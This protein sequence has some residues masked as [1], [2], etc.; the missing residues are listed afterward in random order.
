[1]ECGDLSPLFGEGFSLH[2]LGVSPKWNR[3]TERGGTRSSNPCN[4]RTRYAVRFSGVGYPMPFCRARQACPPN[5]FSEGPAC[6]VHSRFYA[7][8]SRFSLLT[9]MY[10]FSSR[11]LWRNQK[12]REIRHLRGKSRGFLA[13]CVSTPG[14]IR[15]PNRRIRNPLL[16][17]LSY[18]RFASR[19]LEPSVILRD[20]APTLRLRLCETRFALCFLGRI[21]ASV[22]CLSLMANK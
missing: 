2:N 8:F 19:I 13:Y 7:G 6:Q 1:M 11:T 12:P 5:H 20:N 16:Y 9:R 3:V 14:G 22:S 4:R 15:T 18:G 10:I 21:G 17:P